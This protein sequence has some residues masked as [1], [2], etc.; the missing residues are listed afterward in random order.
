MTDYLPGYDAWKTTNPDDE[1]LGPEPVDE[2]EEEDAT[3][4]AAI[5]L[6]VSLLREGYV[7]AEAQQI[8]VNSYGHIY[9]EATL[10]G[11][12]AEADQLTDEPDS[13]TPEGEEA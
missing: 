13:F 5:T 7:W 9:P 8:V 10:D 11:I 1:F 3:R 6:A 2:D 12:M 4:A